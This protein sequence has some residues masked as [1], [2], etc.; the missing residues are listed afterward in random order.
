MKACRKFRDKGL[1]SS[2]SASEAVTPIVG[3]LL[4]LLIL[5]V[6]AGA[7]SGI[8]FNSVGEDANSQP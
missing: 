8:I 6:L 2:E 1:F 4:T 7:I 3:S 5:V